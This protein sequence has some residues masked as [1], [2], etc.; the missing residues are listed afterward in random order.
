MSGILS[1]SLGMHLR[2]EQRLTPQLIQSMAILQKPVA[3][4]EAYLAD[5]LES[6]PALEVAEPQP[7]AEAGVAGVETDGRG[8]EAADGEENR[9]ARLDRYAREYDLDSDDRA[10]NFS[11]RTSDSGD[12]DAKLGALANTAGR[13]E[14]LHEYLID[15]WSLLDLPPAIERG[16]RAIIDH[17]DP[18]GYLR[19]R[20]DGVTANMREPVSEAELEQALAEVHKLHP[21][22]IGARDHIECLLLQLDVLPGNNEIER[23]LIEHHLDDITHNRL[24]SVAKTTGYSVEEIS[25]AIKAMRSTLCLHPGYLIGDRS[26]PTIRP[27]V[28]VEY[29]ATGGGLTV[30]LAR[31]NMPD[32]HIREDIAALAKAKAKT[33]GKATRDFARKHVEAA[34]ALIDAVSFRQSRLLDVA[35]AI[36]EKQRDF[37]DVGPQG[38]KVLRMSDMAVELGCDPSTVSRTVAE[39]YMQTPRGIYPLRYFFTGGR[40][41]DDGESMG[42]DQVKTRVKEIVD[43]E[44]KKSPLNDD[45]IAAILAKEDMA[46]S[47]RTV[48]KYR[49]QLSI[50][51]ARQR[52]QFA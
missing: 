5:Q 17:L 36:V 18:D 34:T 52:R 14:S 11:R 49:Q 4:L 1:Q 33:N 24:P 45:Q 9:F 16:G 23:R 7:S 41:T 48:A 19:V 44:D 46:I 12:R 32:L 43:N 50:P 30:R 10:P 51:A 28:I 31:G 40:E 21:P 26:V 3:D 15:Q 25:E 35:R 20:F 29:A 8:G 2:M 39:K 47:R 6:N 22:G 42:W 13:A 27:D 38:L 37:F